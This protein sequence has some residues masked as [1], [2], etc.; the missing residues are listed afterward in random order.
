MTKL[1]LITG[2]GQGIGAA[3]VTLFTASGWDVIAVD[4]LE[5]VEVL[6]GA[7]YR[8]VDLADPTEIEDLIDFLK[9]KSTSLEALVN[10]AAIQH[11]KSIL[12][13]TNEEWEQVQATNVQAIFVTSRLAYPLLSEHLSH[14]GIAHNDG[15]NQ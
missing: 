7:R 3:T 1:A 13:T 9:E 15:K 8:R 10:N 14:F 12:E 11:N 5:E 4:K 2:A 6:P